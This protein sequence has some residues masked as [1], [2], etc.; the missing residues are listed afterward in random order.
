MRNKSDMNFSKFHLLLLFLVSGI[1]ITISWIMWGLPT[2][3]KLSEVTN[4]AQEQHAV[5]YVMAKIQNVV[6]LFT[7]DGRE[8]NRKYISLADQG[9]TAVQAKTPPNAALVPP[10]LKKVADG[11][12]AKKALTDANKNKTTPA[13]NMIAKRPNT[14]P[15]NNDELRQKRLAEWDVYNKKMQQ[16][17]ERKKK[18]LDVKKEIEQPNQ[19]TETATTVNPPIP[20][21]DEKP[22]K[23]IE[24]WRSELLAASSPEAARATM[25]K[26]IGAYK[27]KQVEEIDFYVTVQGFLK[28]DNEAHKGLGLYALRGTPSYASYLLLIKQQTEFSPALQKYIQETLMSYHNGGLMTYQQALISKDNQVIKKTLEVL[29]TGIANI[30]NG[31]NDGL[32]DARYRRETDQKSLNLKNYLGFTRILTDLGQNADAQIKNAASEINQLINT[33][34]TQ[35]VVASTP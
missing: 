34:A 14:R 29:K 23:S 30:K 22:K 21:T 25:V 27:S 28:S 26:F 6:N 12:K 5:N 8:I 31:T 17:A 1:L 11:L 16:I 4:P 7:L 20:P 15:V 18:E 10:Q 9:P 3:G 13:K 2:S 35:P 32:V 33:G 24:E 19:Y